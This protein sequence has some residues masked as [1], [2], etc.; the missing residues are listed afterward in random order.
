MRFV[1][2]PMA[3]GVFFCQ[4]VQIANNVSIN[5]AVFKINDESLQGFD[6]LPS[7]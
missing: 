3:L 7:F 1:R 4:S 6:N 5:R 2:P